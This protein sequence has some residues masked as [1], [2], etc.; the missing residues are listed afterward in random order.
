M[1]HPMPAALHRS[2][3]FRPSV[4]LALAAL[5]FTLH[6]FWA[7]TIRPLNAPDEPAYLQ[8]VMQVRNGDLL[9][10]L[11]FDFTANPAGQLVGTPGDRDA[12]AYI[13]ATGYT[14][15]IR[16]MPYEAVQPPLYFWLA[17]GLARLLPPQPQTILYLSRLVAVLFGALT[18][19]FSWAAIRQLAPRDPQWAV[20]GAGVIMLLPEF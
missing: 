20:A 12:Q 5:S 13:Q 14:D 9:P 3:R 4:G 8:T 6:L 16:L 11:H 7:A 1:V 19:Y 17:G 2:R 10:E 18:V 15:P